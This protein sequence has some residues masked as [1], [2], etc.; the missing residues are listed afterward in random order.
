MTTEIQIRGAGPVGLACALFLARHWPDPSAIEITTAGHAAPGLAHRPLAISAG[1]R[2]LIERVAQFPVESGQITTVEVALSGHLGRVRI[3]AQDLRCALLGNVVRHGALVECLEAALAGSGVRRVVREPNADLQS[4]PGTLLVHADGDPGAEADV[5]DFG[6]SALLAEVRLTGWT[7]GRALELFTPEGPLAILPLPEPHR[8][9]LVWCAPD[10]VTQ[11]RIQA[12]AEPPNEAL[13]GA[14]NGALSSA[15]SGALKGALGTSIKV[16][17]IEHCQVMPLRR[18]TRGKL[19][20]PDPSQP[21][22]WI[23]NA[24][25]TLHPVAGQGLNL[26]LRDAHELAQQLS[27]WRLMGGGNLAVA[28][29][30]NLQGLDHPLRQYERARRNDRAT[31]V[32]ITDTLATVFRATALAPMQSVALAALD[33]NP[34]LRRAL[35]RT[36][37]Q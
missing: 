8:W 24:A 10:A 26:G 22:V 29:R 27:H 36:F 32:R 1:S 7:Q 11:Q 18:R 20:D 25:Q 14:L 6:Q 37:A 35:A 30:T 3:P 9:A 16:H 4:E 15:L 34:A 28:H 33:L 12:H 13:N 17:E 19:I 31:T 2:R 5:R 23:G 21:Q